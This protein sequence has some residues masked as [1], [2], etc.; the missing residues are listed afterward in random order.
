MKSKRI[1][2]EY[3]NNIITIVYSNLDSSYY[4]CYLSLRNNAK[5][6]VIGDIM[7]IMMSVR[8]IFSS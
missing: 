7:R 3:T 6:D 5:G 2:V 1:R 8:H 4:V